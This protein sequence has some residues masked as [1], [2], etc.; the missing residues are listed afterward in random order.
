MYIDIHRHSSDSGDAD[1][2]L[3]NVFHNEHGR[4]LSENYCSV[5]LHPWH[6]NRASLVRDLGLVGKMA[7]Q[8]NVLA[9]GETG[10]DKAVDID[11]ETQR[12]A[13][14]AQAEIAK[15]ANKP[16]IIHCV[17]AYDE[18]L[19]LRKNSRHKQPWI[20][21]WFNAAPQTAFDL[22][23]KGCYLSFGITLFKEEGKA[24]KSFGQIPLDRVFFETDDVGLSIKEVYEKAAFLRNITMDKLMGQIKLNFK[25]CFGKSL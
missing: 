24:F 10:L 21:H 20:F 2:V 25:N 18:L 17:K 8:S 5:G 19:S 7:L 11:I 9:I 22:I 1:V 6:I 23:A 13:F 3:R 14:R 12:E 15:M 4:V 16:L